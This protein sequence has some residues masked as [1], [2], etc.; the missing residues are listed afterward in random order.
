MA[1]TVA[2]TIKEI[3]RV[4]LEQQNSLLFGQAITAV[5]WVNNTVPDCRGIVEFPMADVSNMGIACGAAIAGR[6]PIIVIRFQDFM[7]LNSSPLVN[8]AAKSKDIFG[9]STPIFVRALAMENAGCTH[10]G[11]LH[12]LFMHMPGF[13]ICSPMTPGEYERVWDDFMTHDDPMLVSEHR[14]SFKN[15]QEFENSDHAADVTL[16]GIS[17]ARF[18]L[19]GAVELLARQELR[20]N[21]AHL[22]RLKP[23]DLGPALAALENSR[24]A[25]VVD[26]GYETCGAAQAAAYELSWQTGKPAKA[27]GLYDRSVGVS[28]ASRNETPSAERIAEVVVQAWKEKS[29]VKDQ[30]SEMGGSFHER[31]YQ[32]ASL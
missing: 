31:L 16:V 22:V 4:H 13:R 7:W 18:N 20:C 3:T 10:S 5:G 23:W 14:S 11:V 30:K 26:A 21:V 9:T 12:S 29:K 32:P 6:R 19:A 27:L 25:V 28:P 1:R 15:D 8:Y 2:E 17:A 24:M